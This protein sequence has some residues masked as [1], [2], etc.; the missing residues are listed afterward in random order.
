MSVF[1]TLERDGT[2]HPLHEDHVPRVAMDAAFAAQRRDF[3]E[4]VHNLNARF[5]SYVARGE[6][7]LVRLRRELHVA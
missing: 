7:E 6:E 3:A 5:T 1:V 2:P 4:Y